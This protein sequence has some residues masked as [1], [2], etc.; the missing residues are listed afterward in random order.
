MREEL[1]DWLIAVHTRFQFLGE[2]LHLTVHLMDRFLSKKPV[3]RRKLQLVALS[4][5][6]IASKYEETV[7]PSI[8]EYLNVTDNAYSSKEL[9]E[10]E[11]F[12]L[13]TLQYK[14]GWPGPLGFLRRSNKAEDYDEQTRTMAKFYLEASLLVGD[15]WVGVMSASQAA[16]GALWLARMRLS[17]GDWN[18][19]LA[20]MAGH[21][22]DE[23]EEAADK[24][25]HY[26]KSGGRLATLCRKWNI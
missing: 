26:I 2:T 8:A 18:A 24:L 13:S 9:L 20:A 16:A 4:A 6:F 22:A 10:A 23:A 21:S 3:S 1:V 15:G 25:R 5:L 7:I 17:R 12:M 11:R 14:L 19:D